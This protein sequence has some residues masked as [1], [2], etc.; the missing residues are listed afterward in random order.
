[1]PF[2][3]LAGTTAARDTCSHACGPMEADGWNCPFRGNL[4]GGPFVLVYGGS[5][6]DEA[7]RV[8][9]APRGTA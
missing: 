9:F 7:V 8:A 4:H 1:M 5:G 3:E 2:R 6:P